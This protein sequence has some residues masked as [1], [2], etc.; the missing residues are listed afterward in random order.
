MWLHNIPFPI[1]QKVFFQYQKLLKLC[2]WIA[3]I[4]AVCISLCTTFFVDIRLA[5]FI[6][7]RENPLKIWEWQQNCNYPNKPSL[8]G[9][10]FSAWMVFRQMSNILRN[11]HL[12]TRYVCR[13]QTLFFFFAKAKTNPWM[14]EST[15]VFQQWLKNIIHFQASRQTEI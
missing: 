7:L 4:N 11:L 12:L 10:F 13:R 6:L 15:T 3:Y 8:I 9:R 2:I 5:E 14:M 1:Y